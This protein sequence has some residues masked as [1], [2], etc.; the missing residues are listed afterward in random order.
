[1]RR[2]LPTPATETSA[3][4]D[5][6]HL[7]QEY[8]YPPERSWLRANMVASVDGA[9]TENGR[10]G[11]LSSGADR[12]LFAILRARADV[13][14]AGATTVR[15]EGYGPAEHR[16]ELVAWRRQA[17]QADA[18]A[19]AVVSASLD[20]DPEAPLFRRALVPTILITTEDAPADRRAA[21]ERV[22]Q[23]LVVGSGRVDLGRAVDGLAAAGHRRMLCEGGPQLLGQLAGA[24]LVD[25]LC[26][27][28]SPRLA[29]DPVRGLVEGDRH[30]RQQTPLELAGLLEQDGY[31]FA[32]YLRERPVTSTPYAGS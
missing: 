19:I 30:T 27:T 5:E 3:D 9:T 1:M 18:A 24:N 17:G 2:L 6:P 7:W 8:D 13:I 25:E 4:L 12:R 29:G 28:I 23:V 32:R 16:A 10:S 26:L 14:I 20:L 31:L 11:G 22:A 15:V 21:F